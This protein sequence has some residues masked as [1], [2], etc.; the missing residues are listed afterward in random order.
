MARCMGNPTMNEEYPDDAQRAAVCHSQWRRRNRSMQ[1]VRIK[2]VEGAWEDKQMDGEEIAAWLKDNSKDG[3]V[4]GDL[5]LFADANFDVTKQ[6]DAIEWVMSDMSLDR[7]QERVDP[8]GADFKNFKRN[9]VVLWA[10]DYERPAIG[11]ISSPKVKDGK[12]TGKVEFDSKDNDEFAYMIGQKVKKG[13]ISGGSI[14]FKPT[15]VE[16]VEEPKDNTRLIHRK[17]ELMEFSICN[18]PANVNALAVR[19]EDDMDAKALEQLKALGEKV[20]MIEA[21]LAKGDEKKSYITELLKDRGEPS[22]VSTEGD[23]VDVTID[24]LFVA[25]ESS[26]QKQTDKAKELMF[27]L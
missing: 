10:H 24:G 13:F 21:K 14:G 23:K 3:Q 22:A 6:E 2:T 26:A 4:C 20:A 7:D 27:G 1:H 17:W 18:V 11:K 25:S 19:A 9:P 15:T 12:V 8:A 5:V 16:F